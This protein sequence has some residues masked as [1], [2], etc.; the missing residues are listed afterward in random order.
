[1]ESGSL[2]CRE[3]RLLV[4][5]WLVDTYDN[6]VVCPLQVRFLPLCHLHCLQGQISDDSSDK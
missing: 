5:E 6:D 2:R 1:M 3:G 4:G